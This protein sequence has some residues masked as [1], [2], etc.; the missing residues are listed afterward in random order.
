MAAR[1]CPNCGEKE[2][3]VLYSRPNYN[4]LRNIGVNH[5]TIR[6]N[7]VCENCGY[8]MKTYEIDERDLVAVRETL[9]DTRKKARLA[10]T[11]M[12]K[13]KTAIGHCQDDLEK[14]YGE[15]LW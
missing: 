15:P 2:L 11:A 10:K 4:S 8:K 3:Y 1:K 13:L 14:I 5:K 6:R 12:G 9:L 7:L